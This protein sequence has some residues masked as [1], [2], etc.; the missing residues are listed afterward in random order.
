MG[1][2]QE[3]KAKIYDAC[4]RESDELQRIN[5]KL[6]SAYMFN[7]PVHIMD[8]ISRNDARI[9][10]LVNKLESLFN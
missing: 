9:N 7:A 3:E 6:K 8:E 5:S 2:S 4:I 1:L 10:Y